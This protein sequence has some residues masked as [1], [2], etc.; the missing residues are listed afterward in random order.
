M[1]DYEFFSYAEYIKVT[2]AIH[3]TR[4]NYN[5]LMKILNEKCQRQLYT[6]ANGGFGSED[7]SLMNRKNHTHV[8]FVFT[9]EIKPEVEACDHNYTVFERFGDNNDAISSIAPDYCPKCGERLK[10]E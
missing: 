8:R 4:D 10:N 5:A 3:N 7:T 2:P 9:K 1:S 6:P